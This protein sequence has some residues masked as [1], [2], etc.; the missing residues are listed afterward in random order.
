M[1][2]V[3]VALAAAV[4][5]LVPRSGPP[6]RPASVAVDGP[7]VEAA[8]VLRAWDADRAEAWARGSVAALR[9]LYVEGAGE[10]DAA[11]LRDY[12]RRGLTVRDLRVQVLAL[13]VLRHR[14]GEWLLRVT[15]RVAAGVVTSRDGTQQPLP[16]DRATTR[17]VLLVRRDAGWRVAEVVPLAS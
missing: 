17:D 8:A 9:R 10:R 1:P 11:L 6:P 12:F 5:L 15:D 3:L 4:G 2:A 13:E 16:R 7:T 14:P